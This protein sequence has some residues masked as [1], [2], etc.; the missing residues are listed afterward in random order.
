[1]DDRKINDILDGMEK[2]YSY[3]QANEGVLA[4]LDGAI[5]IMDAVGEVCYVSLSS[6]C[7]RV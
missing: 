6:A 2:A 4:T 5:Q 3:V 7:L 1:L